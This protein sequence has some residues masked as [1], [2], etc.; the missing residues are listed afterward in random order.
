MP[1]LRQAQPERF[2]EAHTLRNRRGPR[3]GP[4]R[5]GRPAALAAS[6]L[7]GED[8]KRLR[9]CFIALAAVVAR[10]HEGGGADFHGHGL[11]AHDGVDARAGG[12]PGADKVLAQLDNPASVARKRVG[13]VALER[14][15][16]REHTEL[17]TEGGQ[18]IGEVTSGLLGPSFDKPIALAYVDPQHA[19]VGTRVHAMV[20]GKAV[21]M[22]VCATPFVPTR[23]YR[24]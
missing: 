17:Q 21:P 3:P 22:E 18:K 24:G 11:A 2:E 9:G 6:P 15:P 14:V 7:K 1:W 5:K 23:Y 4:P 16:V 10:G 19:A 13:L 8:A 20:R 12:F